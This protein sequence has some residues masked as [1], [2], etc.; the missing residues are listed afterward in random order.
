MK[1][2]YV[3]NQVT[4]G[5]VPAFRKWEFQVAGPAPYSLVQSCPGGFETATKVAALV[6]GS[7]TRNR[8]LDNGT[9]A[10]IRRV[11]TA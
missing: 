1:K 7:F 9:R 3:H 10:N 2:T 5:F 11:V 4:Y 6:S 8:V